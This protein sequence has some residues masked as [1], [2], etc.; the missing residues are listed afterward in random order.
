MFNYFILFFINNKH[1]KIT[2]YLYT[3]TDKVLQTMPKTI[4]IKIYN[5]IKY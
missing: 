1:K 3:Y 5:L 4:N 2:V